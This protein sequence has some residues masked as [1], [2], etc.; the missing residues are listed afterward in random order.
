[1]A[2][3][4]AQRLAMLLEAIDNEERHFAELRTEHKDCMERLL[5]Q[6][7]KLRQEILTG[8]MGLPVEPE[9]A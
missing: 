4:R 8:Q 7:Y 1:M 3:D 9:A 5:N 6:A 2:D